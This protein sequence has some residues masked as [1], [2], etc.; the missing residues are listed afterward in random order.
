[1]RRHPTQPLF[2]N[3]S[4]LCTCGDESELGWSNL[5]PFQQ[6]VRMGVIRPFDKV[7]FSLGLGFD[8]PN[9]LSNLSGRCG[10]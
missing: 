4:L 9:S 8:H 6:V 1:M 10:V 7:L 2:Y 3:L 5:K